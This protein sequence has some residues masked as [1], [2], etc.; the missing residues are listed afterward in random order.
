MKGR[1]DYSAED[2]SGSNLHFGVREF[3]MA[4]ICNGLALHGGLRPYCATFFVFSDYIARHAP[5]GPD[6]HP[7]DLCAHPRLHRRGRGRPTHEPIEHLAMLRSLPGMTVY[8]PADSH[9][10]A[11]GWYQA[12]TRKGPVSLVLTRQTP[13]PVRHHRQGGPQGRLYPLRQPQG[14][15]GRHPDGLGLG[16]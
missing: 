13:A 3:A 2:R 8:R 14:H 5:V 11:A 7:G 4:A 6:G 15:A 1:G 10:V 12:M 9:E 16:G